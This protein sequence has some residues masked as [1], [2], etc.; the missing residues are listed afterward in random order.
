MKR[1][2]FVTIAL[3]VIL[4]SACG[5]PAPAPAAAPTQAQAPAA[6]AVGQITDYAIAL[7]PEGGTTC[8]AD[9]T[10]LVTATITASG[11]VAATY[12]VG[13]SS[14][15]GQIPTGGNFQDLT[16]NSLDEYV[17]AGLTF[18]KAETKTLSWR[19]AGPYA[20][21]N[22]I[23]V[24]LR[25]NDGEFKTAKLDC[26]SAAP[27]LAPTQPAATQPP[28]AAGCQD[29][30]QYVSDDGMDGT[31]YAPNTPFTKTWKIKN[32]GTC[33]WDSSYLA[34]YVSGATMSQSPAYPIVPSG[35]QVAP[36]GVVDIS[37]GMTSPSEPGDYNAN[38]QL[39]DSAGKSLAQFYLKIKVK[40]QDSG[41]SATGTITN[42][43]ARIV[44]EQGSG[45]P[46]N[47]NATYFVYVDIT[48]DGPASAE[49][50]IY[51]T[52]ASGQVPNGIFEDHAA[53]QADGT[54]T[55]DA[56]KTETVS[57]HVV[58][59]YAYP[60]SVTVRVSVNGTAWQSATASCQ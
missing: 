21:P 15:G 32:T 12:E 35:G 25:V 17:K 3:I 54:W 1:L 2:Q 6:P 38:W 8:S 10:Y 29:S 33:T 16:T 58:G 41:G 26:G 45:A 19:L 59:P 39:Q 60:D 40:G 57:L 30:A 47:A 23:T 48:A 51:L 42:V 20:Y 24:K 9:G 5:S 56:A 53:P 36:G 46:C 50:Q 14:S 4:L 13:S 43:I 37:V 28:A 7:A 44:Q 18:D 27:Q 11:V 22:D 52:D 55:F 49:Y 31:A 34:Y